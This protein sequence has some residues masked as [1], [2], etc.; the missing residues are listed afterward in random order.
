MKR[1][2]LAGAAVVMAMIGLTAVAANAQDIDPAQAVTDLGTQVNL[3]WVVIGAVLV[4]FMQAGLRAGRD[5]L[6]PGQAR[7]PR[8]EHELRHLR[9]RL[10][11]LLPRRLRLHVRRLLGARSSA[12]T[13]PIGDQP[14]RLRRAGSSCGR[15]ASPSPTWSV[16]RRRR[17]GHGLL[18]L[19]GR[20]HG[21]RGH[22]PHRGHGRAV[23]VEQPS[24]AGASSAAPSTTR[25]SAPGPGAAAGWPS[26]ATRW[27]S[28]TATS[29]SPA[30]ASC[31][32][33]AAWPPWPAPSCSGPASASSTRTARPT[34]CPATTSRWPCSAPSSCCSA[35]SASTP[36]RPS[37]RP[38]SS[39]PS[40]PPNTAIAGA[41][42][43]V[44][45][46]F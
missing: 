19:H 36:P 46:M 1:K 16:R 2:L 21:H 27:T 39:S 28:A 11:R 18:P 6:L 43:A 44:A 23:E 17:G 37:R 35:G 9:P 22:D 25:C 34:R 41:F 5:R 42:G 20:L 8:G 13:T 7:R 15:A 40:S 38:T 24:S 33:S 3:L 14:D 45:A 31:T 26:S 29:T 10:R 30:P 4:I 32:P 12:S